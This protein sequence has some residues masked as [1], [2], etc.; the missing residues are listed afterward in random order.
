M[1]EILGELADPISQEARQK[2]DQHRMP[3]SSPPKEG[4]RRPDY[5]EQRRRITK[6]GAEL[7][8]RVAQGRV[9]VLKPVQHALVNRL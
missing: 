3:P 9:M 7:H 1:N 4:H 6:V 5:A 8:Q 2:Q